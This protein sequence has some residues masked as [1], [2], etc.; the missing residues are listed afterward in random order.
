[1]PPARIMPFMIFTPGSFAFNA[2]FSDF[3]SSVEPLITAAGSDMIL[4]KLQHF[5]QSF[6]TDPAVGILVHKI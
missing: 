2:F 3:N 6:L 4:F 5:C 1:M